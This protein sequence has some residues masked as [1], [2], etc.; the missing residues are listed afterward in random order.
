MLKQVISELYDEG[1]RN[2]TIKVYGSQ[3]TG[4]DGDCPLIEY[5]G[6]Y[7]YSELSD[8]LYHLDGTLVPS[9]WYETFSLVTLESLA[10]GRPAIVSDHVGAKDIVAEYSPKFIFSDKEEL[11]A[12]LKE[13]VSDNKILREFNAAIL[14]NN[15]HFSL[16][17][18]TKE[19]LNLYN[20]VV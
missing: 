6:M 1:I 9:K 13:C 19:I 12:L 18:H 16:A 11:K 15:W 20:E 10:H 7:K 2:I 5:C 3:N 4:I 17:N 14:N 8:V